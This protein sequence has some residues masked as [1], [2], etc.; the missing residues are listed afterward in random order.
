MIAS[1]VALSASISSRIRSSGG[2]NSSLSRLLAAVRFAS[3]SPT[4]EP[5]RW[6][7]R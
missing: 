1:S 5:A 2:P 3:S 7:F 4:T 6:S